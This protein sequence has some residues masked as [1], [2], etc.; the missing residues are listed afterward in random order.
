MSKAIDITINDWIHYKKQV[1]VEML[2]ISGLPGWGKTSMGNTLILEC[3]KKGESWVIPGDRFCEWRH[4][5]KYSLIEEIVII[6]PLGVE[7]YYHGDLLNKWKLNN[8][9]D[10]RF[11]ELDYSKLNI[12]DYLPEDGKVRMVVVYDAH[13]K[14]NLRSWLWVNISNQLLSRVT[15]LNS[16]IG[17]LFNEAGV[18]FPQNAQGDHWK[19]VAEFA[20]AIVDARKGLLRLIYVSQIQTEIMDTVRKKCLFKVFRKG[21]VAKDEPKAI[22]KA[23][24]FTARNEY[25]LSCGGLYCKSNTIDKFIE[26]KAIQKMIPQVII[27]NNNEASLPTS[28]STVSSIDRGSGVVATLGENNENQSVKSVSIKSKINSSRRYSLGALIDELDGS[29]GEEIEITI[30]RPVLLEES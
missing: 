21:W 22:R 30:K 2:H 27:N 13:Y 16:C 29:T 12:M 4:F 8:N 11:V 28:S 23:A 1:G 26:E 3:S 6:I 24:P 18:L 14:I 20:T 10:I 7:I 9:N 5:H 15:H 19:A 17:I 25:H